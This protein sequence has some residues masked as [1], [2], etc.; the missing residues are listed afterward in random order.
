MK[1]TLPNYRQAPRKVRLV[2]DLIKGKKVVDAD[3]ELSFLVKRAAEPIQKLLKSAIANAEKQGLNKED[4]YIKSVTVNKGTV[5]KRYMPR[6]FGR[7]SQILKRSSHL[8]IELAV[9][10]EK[11]SKKKKVSKSKK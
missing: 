9:K 3:T 11:E 4:L 8:E 2:T 5:L 10:E 1:A 7:A 6:A